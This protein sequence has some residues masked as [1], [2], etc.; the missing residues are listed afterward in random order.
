MT[1]EKIGRYEVKAELG[2]GGMATVFTAYDPMFER[3]VAIKALPREFLHEPEFQARF[4][5][6]AK[7]IAALEHPAIVPVYD[8]GEDNGQPYLVMR[9]M[10]GGSLA[11]KLKDGVVPIEEAAVILKRLGSALDHAHTQGIIHRDLK[12]GNILF[13]QYGDAYL[14]DFGIVHVAASTEALTASGSL[15]GTPMY[16]SPE[17]VYGDKELDGRSDVYALGI[18]LFQMLTG[19]LPFTGDTPARVMMKHVMDPVPAI[20]EKRPD[21]PR[22]TEEVIHKALAK[23]RDD[24]FSSA[25]DLSQALSKAT[26]KIPR[27]DLSILETTAEK[28]ETMVAQAAPPT[29]PPAE[30]AEKRTVFEPPPPVAAPPPP[31]PRVSPP[32]QSQPRLEAYPPAIEAKSKRKIPLW[33]I[34]VASMILLLCAGVI[35]GGVWLVT[36]T[37]FLSTATPTWPSVVAA[38][39]DTAITP[40]SAAAAA[41][42][43]T[44]TAISEA[45]VATATAQAAA[46][47]PIATTEPPPTNPPPA[48]DATTESILATRAALAAESGN[49]TATARPIV[50]TANDDLIALAGPLNGAIAHED[51]S[52]IETEYLEISPADFILQATFENP[53]G[54]AD[55]RWDAGIIFRQA[56]GDDEL[57]L[58]FR[59]DGV[60]NLNNRVDSEDNF[61]AEGDLSAY[62]DSSANGENEVV[63]VALADVGYFFLNGN[64]VSFLTFDGRVNTGNIAIGTGFYSSDEVAGESTGYRNLTVWSAN[65]L[66]GPRSNQLDHVDDGLIKV[67]PAEINQFNFIADAV[68]VNPY[69]T[70][71]SSWDIGLSFRETAYDSQM[72]LV[73][74]SDGNWRLIDR[75]SGEDI[76]LDE[77]LVDDL[78]DTSDDAANRITLI[79]LFDRGYFLLNDSLVA[80]LDL[81]SRPFSGDVAVITAFFVED[82]VF[83][84][85]TVYEDFTIWGLP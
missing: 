19:E 59:S 50:G 48:A 72:W 32:P 11:D 73:V 46:I 2:R 84:E 47:Q 51:D 81:S 35:G 24:R 40:T 34:G 66:F 80:E 18:I 67:R 68:F 83:G 52:L 6:E 53:F 56:G 82:E 23:Q 54:A 10:P 70:S 38:V 14:A 42:D 36:Q 62:L 60:W 74:G 44:A 20:L 27:P 30:V 45:R 77:G 29:P 75:V 65:P 33:V 16:M 3:T 55:G 39:E 41:P 13:D 43:S 26:Q 5:R 57:R 71:V 12:P 9:Y 7:T 4:A 17:Q 8:F 79:A 1:P 61:L 37:D 76:D 85:A 58:V 21:L 15:V 78:L 49:A 25:T 22:D 28:D 64:L 69:P 31:P 63:L